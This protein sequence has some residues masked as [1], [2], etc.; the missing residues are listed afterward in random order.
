MKLFST[1]LI[2]LLLAPGLTGQTRDQ[3]YNDYISEYHRIATAQ[4]RSHR[5]PA[6]I[7]LAQGLLESGAGRSRL[8][9]KPIT[10]LALNATSGQATGFITM[11]M[12]EM[13]VSANTTIPVS[14]SKIIPSF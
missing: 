2:L 4:Q 7:I 6:S 11:T 13:N 10:I 1:L 5:I 9:R 8:A 3:L 12:S 14:R